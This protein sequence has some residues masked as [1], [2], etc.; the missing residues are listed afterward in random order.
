MVMRPMLNLSAAAF[1]HLIGQAVGRADH[2]GHV[3]CPTVR[4]VRKELRQ[5]V[6]GD[7]PALNA[8]SHDGSTLAHVGQD[9]LALLVQ[10]LF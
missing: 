5:L 8:H 1:F 7:L 10:C 3:S 6:G 2:K 9:G 4:T